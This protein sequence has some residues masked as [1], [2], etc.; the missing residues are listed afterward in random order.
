MLIERG[1][2]RDDSP[3]F[4]EPDAFVGAPNKPRPHL[5]SGAVA[6]PEPDDTDF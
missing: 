4:D 5:N 3:D 1:F 2:V 6:P